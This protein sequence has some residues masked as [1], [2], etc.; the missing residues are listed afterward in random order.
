[1]QRSHLAKPDK[2]QSLI[3]GDLP[4]E[5][6]QH[7]LPGSSPDYSLALW[8]TDLN[9]CLRNGVLL[10]TLIPAGAPAANRANRFREGSNRNL[11]LLRGPTSDL[12]TAALQSVN[13]ANA[14]VHAIR[15]RFGSPLLQKSLPWA[16]VK[17]C[18]ALFRYR[19]GPCP[20][21]L[22]SQD[23]LRRCQMS[24]KLPIDL[25]L[26]PTSIHNNNSTPSTRT[27]PGANPNLDR[28][29]QLLEAGTIQLPQLDT[30]LGT[31]THVLRGTTILWFQKNTP[32][33]H[34]HD[35]D[36]DIWCAAGDPRAY[37]HTWAGIR[38]VEGDTM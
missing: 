19:E 24:S 17:I 29:T 8:E 23:L 32:S 10:P 27:I 3:P 13:S 20:D 15:A 33:D 26:T 9:T 5:L 34:D 7:W 11:N 22:R 30:P 12:V 6:S 21:S 37:A 35:M 31:W 18:D 14:S 25:A 36:L 16:P 4:P 28:W 38:L 2:W 1:M